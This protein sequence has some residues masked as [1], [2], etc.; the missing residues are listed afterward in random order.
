VNIGH[1][2]SKINL[3]FLDHNTVIITA[4]MSSIGSIEQMVDPGT[5]EPDTTVG[6]ELEDATD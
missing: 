1:L 2:E 4:Q 5:A 6:S 3:S